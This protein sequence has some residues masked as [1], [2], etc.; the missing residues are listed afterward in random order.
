MIFRPA[1]ETNARAGAATGGGCF[2]RGRRG[3]GPESARFLGRPLAVDS[4]AAKRSRLGWASLLAVSLTW[5]PAPSAQSEDQRPQSD[6]AAEARPAEPEPE[7]GERARREAVASRMEVSAAVVE[8]ASEPPPAGQE[9]TPVDEEIE[10]MAA[11]DAE[12]ADESEPPQAEPAAE[13]FVPSEDIS[14]DFAVPFPVDI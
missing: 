5:S 7:A 10:P 3:L 13:I 14:E 12:R 2:M 1:H 11:D 9:A 4:G 8:P 6:A